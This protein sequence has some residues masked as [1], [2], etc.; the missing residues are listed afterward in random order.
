MGTNFFNA[1][2]GVYVNR[3]RGSTGD[4][5]WYDV[6]PNVLFYQ[7]NALYPNDPARDQQALALALKWHEACVAL[8]GKTDPL[9]LPNFDHTGLESQDHAAGGEGMDRAG[10]APPASRG[11]NTWRGSG[12]R[13]RV[14]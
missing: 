10:S 12:S 11:W 5:F 3:L 1:D 2:E 9:A 4:S 8:G 7:L 14:S 13:T 6:F